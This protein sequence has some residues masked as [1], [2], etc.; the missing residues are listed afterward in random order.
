MRLVHT[1]C[2]GCKYNS[3]DGICR[4]D[5]ICNGTERYLTYM[6]TSTSPSTF[7]EQE[8]PEEIEINGIK[9]RREQ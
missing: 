8:L 9:Y 2:W 3:Y 5:G 7:S 6:A 1:G 4:K